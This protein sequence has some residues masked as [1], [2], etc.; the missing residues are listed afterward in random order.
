MYVLCLAQYRLSGSNNEFIHNLV[1]FYLSPYVDYCCS[2]IEVVLYYDPS[3]R[4]RGFP[5][6]LIIIQV[7]S[8][9]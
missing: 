7:G 5:L 3:A 4:E 9:Q 8:L 1:N 2:Q 6:T